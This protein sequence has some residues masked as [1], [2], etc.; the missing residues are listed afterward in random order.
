VLRKRAPRTSGAVT[1]ARSW[2]TNEQH[3]TAHTYQ[4]EFLGPFY[5]PAYGV[6]AAAGEI[7]TGDWHNN[8]MESGPMSNPP[9]AFK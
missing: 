6:G 1:R 3:E 4:G 8:F 7:S 2:V 9:K 5:L